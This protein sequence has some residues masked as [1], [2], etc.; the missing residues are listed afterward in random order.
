MLS[1]NYKEEH[2]LGATLKM[3]F[4]ECIDIYFE[5]VRGKMLDAILLNMRNDKRIV[6]DSGIGIRY[7][8]DGGP[9]LGERLDSFHYNRIIHRGMKP[10]NILTGAGCI[11]K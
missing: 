6:G 3:Y 2:D 1:F 9:T 4:P 8:E 10:Q 11:L 5:N 7:F